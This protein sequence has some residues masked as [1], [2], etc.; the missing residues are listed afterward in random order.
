LIIPALFIIIQIREARQNGIPAWDCLHEEEVLLL[1][2]GHAFQGDNPMQ[3][4][5][6]SHIGM[7]GRHFCRICHASALEG[8]HRAPGRAGEISRVTEFMQVMIL[9]FDIF[10]LRVLMKF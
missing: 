9:C 5:F 6:A 10:Y 1:P 8:K 3:S 7:S 4:E 2:W